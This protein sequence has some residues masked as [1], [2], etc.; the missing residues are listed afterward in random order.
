MRQIIL[1]TD[2]RVFRL[3]GHVTAVPSQNRGLFGI[4]FLTLLKPG[5]AAVGI[6]RVILLSITLIQPILIADML[7]LQII[8]GTDRSV[9][10]ILG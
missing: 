2:Q 5:R 3:L 10:P 7:A 4:G 8:T 6:I 1:G 9:F